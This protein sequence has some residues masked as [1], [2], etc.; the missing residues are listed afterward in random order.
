MHAKVTVV[1]DTVFM[2]SFNLSRSGE[3]NA[4]NMIEIEDA[5]V[6]EIMADFIDDTRGK[7]PPSTV[8]DIATK[9]RG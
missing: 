2:G 4:E 1:D 9:F 6:A 7:Y 8:P 3:E 5:G